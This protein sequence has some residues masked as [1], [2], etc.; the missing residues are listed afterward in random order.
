MHDT[1]RVLVVESERGAADDAEGQLAAAGHTVVRCRERG[2]PAF[3]CKGVA[4]GHHCPLDEGV[5]DVALDIRPR[6]R[7]QPAPQEDGVA[8]A[9]RRHVP[10]VVAGS[11]L[12]N[13]YDGYASE[14][15]PTTANLVDVCEKTASAVLREHSRVAARALRIC[16]ERRGIHA[17]PLV[18]VRRRHGAL[19]VS[20]SGATHVDASTKSMASVRMSAALR[21]LDRAARG[22]D[23]VFR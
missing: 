17:M 11:A 9:L 15:V 23:V 4:E 16:L 18:A 6:P 8:C 21:E 3:P 7:S 13:P 19:L 2:A 12:L 5:V 10:V 22:I 14:V 20:V 1:L